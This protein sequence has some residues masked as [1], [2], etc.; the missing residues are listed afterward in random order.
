MRLFIAIPPAPSFK[1][2]LIQI[3]K[4]LDSQ[5]VQGNHTKEENL[6]LTLAFIGEYSDA[7]EIYR[8]SPQCLRLHPFLLKNTLSS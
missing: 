5:G 2:S 6:H 1:E 3:Q 8:F 7:D 4:H